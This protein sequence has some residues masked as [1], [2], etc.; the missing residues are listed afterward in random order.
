MK[1]FMVYI[2]AVMLAAPLFMLAEQPK[3]YAEMASLLG[4]LQEIVSNLTT[5]IQN[6]LPH[7]P[8]A[9]AAPNETDVTGDGENNK[10]D[11]EFLRDRW[12]SGDPIADINGDGIVN[13]VDFGLLNKNWNKKV[14]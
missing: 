10:E 7:T 6:T 12:F 14:Q 5:Q 9:V 3:N 1:R 13:S 11:W 8:I 2:F 4:S